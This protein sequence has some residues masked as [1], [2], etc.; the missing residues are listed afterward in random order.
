MATTTWQFTSKSST[1]KSMHKLSTIQSSFSTNTPKLPSST[2]SPPGLFANMTHSLPAN[3]TIASTQLPDRLITWPATSTPSSTIL[4]NITSTQPATSSSPSRSVSSSTTQAE[5][6][7]STSHSTTT[8]WPTTS[9]WI[10]RSTAGTVGITLATGK[11]SPIYNSTFSAA[12][13]S[14]LPETTTLL[15]PQCSPQD[16][17]SCH[18]LA[19]CEPT[20]GQC[21]CLPGYEG[22]GV[23][24][25]M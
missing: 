1:S 10:S 11:V 4:L 12:R 18:I 8:I 24:T 5:L 2:L 17:S 7:S 16:S 13:S 20:K 22:D 21:Q 3:T 9:Q 23:T 14:P 19:T 25:C 6:S 15:L